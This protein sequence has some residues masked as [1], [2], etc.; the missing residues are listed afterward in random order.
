[1]AA[2]WEGVVQV[3]SP[4]KHG[5]RLS[6]SQVPDEIAPPHGELVER[7]G[8]ALNM[9][10]EAWPHPFLRQAQD[11]GVDQPLAAGVLS[12]TPFALYTLSIVIPGLARDPGAIAAGAMRVVLRG[13]LQNQRAAISRTTTN[14]SSDATP[15]GP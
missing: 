4:G 10:N 3:H 13:N 12:S 15:P 5:N 7:R 9:L 1:M 2:Q 8:G 14:I 11:E 6:N